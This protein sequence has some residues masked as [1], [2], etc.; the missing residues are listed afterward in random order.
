MS[1]VQKTGQLVVFSQTFPAGQQ[2]SPALIWQSLSC[3]QALAQLA[4]HVAPCNTTLPSGEVPPPPGPGPPVVLFPLEHPA[5]HTKPMTTVST[6]TNHCL[7]CLPIIACPLCLPPL[8]M[9]RAQACVCDIFRSIRSDERGPR[10]IHLEP[11]LLSSTGRHAPSLPYSRL[12]RSPPRRSGRRP[13]SSPERRSHRAP[14]RFGG[15]CRRRR[16]RRRPS[17]GRRGETRPGSPVGAA[18]ARR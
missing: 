16:S 8:S 5:G 3:V 6:T 12:T 14:F 7:Q 11:S 1:L 13:R 2:N 9:P 4:W 18:T 10:S 17:R 15:R